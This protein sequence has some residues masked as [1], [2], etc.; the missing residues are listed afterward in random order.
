MTSCSVTRND[1]PVRR[2]CISE[3]LLADST[4]ASRLRSL[5][6]EAAMYALSNALAPRLTEL[7]Q[8]AYLSWFSSWVRS[9]L[10]ALAGGIVR[11]GGIFPKVLRRVVGYS[12]PKDEILLGAAAN[13]RHLKPG[14][15]EEKLVSVEC[16]VIKLEAGSCCLR[17][18]VASG[19]L[20]TV[21]SVMGIGCVGNHAKSV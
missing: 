4:R 10:T 1:L 18:R 5:L 2:L 6:L 15:F 19:R 9:V 8:Y 12:D 11:V 21:E 3:A 16:S 20:N 7:D 13:L 14:K 17:E